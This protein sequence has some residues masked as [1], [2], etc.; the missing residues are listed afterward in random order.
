MSLLDTFSLLF[1]TD[2]DDAAESVSG[3]SDEL[4]RAGSSGEKAAAGIENSSD[5]AERGSESFSGLAKSVGGL[6]AAYLSF[7]A[8]SAAVFDQALATDEVGKFSETVGM[9]IE[10]VDAWSAAV[11]RSGGSSASFRGSVESLNSAMADI[12]LGGGGDIAETL[13]RLGISALDATGRIKEVNNILPE[14]ADSFQNLSKRESVAFGQKLGLDQ[15]TI[16]LLQQGR[17]AVEQMV[18]QQRQLGGR[19]KEGYEASAAF[20][21]EMKD[22]RRMFVGIA[23]AANQRILPMLTAMLD[24]FQ[25]VVYWA[26]DHKDVLTG[27]FIA[28]G[29]VIATVYLPAI[30]SAAAATL[31]AAAPFI[32]IGAAVVAAG[33]A[34]GILYEDVK[35]YLGGQ[36]SFIG[37][38]AEEYEWF[39]DVLE[40]FGNVATGVTDTVADQFRM[41]GK[42]VKGILEFLMNPIDTATKALDSLIDKIPDSVI[43]FFG[44]GD[45]PGM[46][47]QTSTALAVAGAANANPMLSGMGMQGGRTNYVT[48]TNRFDT[49]VDARGMSREDAAQAFS[50]QRAREIAQAKGN[51]D[52]GVDY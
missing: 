36:Q 31:V 20:N 30:V 3:L 23:D 5:A 39:A 8:V 2:A 52:D 51:L 12:A 26:Q 9:A 42:I 22:T 40:F 18:E 11:E 28:V 29:G 13:G 35:A 15:G 38:L 43:D 50:E 6:I 17:D 16:L 47:Q 41:M 24:G 21:D 10:D 7:Q 44:G 4:D 48:Q 25:D 33:A 1:E 45:D 27:F 14:L 49:R 19:T 32:A 37:D 34:F 46:Q